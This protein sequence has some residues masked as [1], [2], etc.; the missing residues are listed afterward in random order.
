MSES[1]SSSQQTLQKTRAHIGA[2][3]RIFKAPSCPAYSSQASNC[4]PSID[5]AARYS[6]SFGTAQR[7]IAQLRA[8]GL[9][10]VSRGKRAVV[11]DPA[12]EV[13][14]EPAKVVGLNTRRAK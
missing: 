13:D 5:L 1:N 3:R 9:V 11:V 4:L 10:S 7:A 8:A 14:A 6:V 12:A 2:S